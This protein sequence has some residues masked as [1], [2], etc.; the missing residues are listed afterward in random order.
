MSLHELLA[1]L[2]KGNQMVEFELIDDDGTGND[3]E[4]DQAITDAPTLTIT[5]S[6]PYCSRF[7]LTEVEWWMN[8]TN[9]VTYEMYL[10]EGAEAQD[11]DS[12]AEVV[13]DSGLGMADSQGYNSAWGQGK[14]PR[15]VDLTIPGLIY[16][17]MDWSGAPGNTPG[18]LRGRGVKMG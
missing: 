17:L 5:L 10:L 3:F 7:L 8:P 9:V 1:I 14:L 6:D 15:I 13:F 18:L 11:V 4:T 16:Y 12:L 2:A